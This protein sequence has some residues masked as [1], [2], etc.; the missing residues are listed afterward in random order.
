VPV[1]RIVEL[2]WERPPPS[3]KRV[4]FAHIARLRKAL[5]GAGPHGVE[6]ASSPAGYML[7]VDPARV[8][9]VRFRRLLSDSRATDDAATRARLLRDA[10]A[11]WRGPVLAGLGAGP[12]ALRLVEGLNELRLSA[13]EDRI[14]GDLAAG[15]HSEAAVELAE[16]VARQPSRERMAGQ[17]MLALYRSGRTAEALEVYRRIRAHLADELGVDPGPELNARHGAILRRD[18]ALALAPPTPVG[19]APPPVSSGNLP[20]DIAGFTGRDDHL[21]RLSALLPQGSVAPVVTLSGL[22]GAGKTALAVHWAHRV[23]DR[24]PG[25]QFYLDLGGY[26]PE[27]DTRALPVLLRALGLAPGQ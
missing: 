1:E 16:Q 7:R 3:A 21:A 11:L 26:R 27:D 8:D 6:L 23:A 24:F 4:V 9:A 12:G 25:G 20:R 10:L 19:S 17:L 18:P 14:D 13:L 5:A 22:G 2:A 15:R